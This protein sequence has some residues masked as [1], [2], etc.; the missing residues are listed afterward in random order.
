MTDVK[1]RVDVDTEL[2]PTG[3]KT[4]VYVGETDIPQ[5]DITESW[6]EIIYRTVQYCT[7]KGK[8]AECHRDE[9]DALISG[10]R[11]ALELFESTVEE[12]GYEK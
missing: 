2:N 9:I 7:I 6:E 12:V 1:L 8:I 3:L 5:V 4:L 11:N 10:L